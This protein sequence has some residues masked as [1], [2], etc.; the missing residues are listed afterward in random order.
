MA[1]GTV[2][3][4]DIGLPGMSDQ[5]LVI[6][7][8]SAASAGMAVRF[9]ALTNTRETKPMDSIWSVLAPAEYRRSW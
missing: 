2:L 9:V 7:A 6:S 5:A 1:D 8:D 3:L 4:A